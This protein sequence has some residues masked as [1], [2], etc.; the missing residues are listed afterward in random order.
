[1]SESD[2]LASA[3]VSIDASEESKQHNDAQTLAAQA[4]AHAAIDAAQ[5]LRAILAELQAWRLQACVEHV[6]EAVAEAKAIDPDL[7]AAL[8]IC[9]LCLERKI[10]RDGRCVQ[11]AGQEHIPEEEA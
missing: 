9:P 3:Q 10:V 5:S 8:G 11:C 7:A 4:E 6:G 1:M 2:Y